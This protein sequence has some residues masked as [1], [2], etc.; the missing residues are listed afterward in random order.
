M[1]M[2]LLIGEPLVL[3]QQEQI[4]FYAADPRPRVTPS[5]YYQLPCPAHYRRCGEI[6]QDN[7]KTKA[8]VVHLSVERYQTEGIRA[9]YH[10]QA[11]SWSILIGESS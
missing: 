9:L 6:I 7:P 2:N 8:R 4:L 3:Q 1:E 10:C 5:C 11:I